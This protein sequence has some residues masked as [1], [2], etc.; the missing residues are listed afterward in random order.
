MGNLALAIGSVG[1]IIIGGISAVV[2]RYVWT[3]KI[4]L[5]K[6]LSGDAAASLSRFNS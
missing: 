6:L 4:D 1:I 3:G 5:T 2:V